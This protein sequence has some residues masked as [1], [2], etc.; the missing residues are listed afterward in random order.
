MKISRI[1]LLLCCALAASGV[2]AARAVPLDKYENVPATG[3]DGKPLPADKVS[4]AIII[5]AGATKW[6]VSTSSAPNTVRATH[7]QRKNTA[8]VDI[9]Y[10]DG[11]YS[12]RYVDSNNLNY[13]DAGGAQ[14]IL[15]TYNKWLKQL[16]TEIDRALKAP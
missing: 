12:I 4:N 14:V 5:A 2:Q 11:S 15:G 1:L 16:K 3:A 7:A 9:T 6:V 13:S 10:A 8:V